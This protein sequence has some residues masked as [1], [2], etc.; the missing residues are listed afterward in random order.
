M[1]N[2]NLPN[3][4]LVFYEYK[5]IYSDVEYQQNIISTYSSLKSSDKELTQYRRP[6]CVGPSGNT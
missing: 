6:V 5:K 3:S 1:K 4:N 2:S